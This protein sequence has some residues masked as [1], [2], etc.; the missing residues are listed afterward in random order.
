[1]LIN[2]IA[3]KQDGFGD[4]QIL[5]SCQEERNKIC[6]IRGTLSNYM[7]EGLSVQRLPRLA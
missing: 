1:M 4:I 6:C 2:S 5:F 7:S 3:R